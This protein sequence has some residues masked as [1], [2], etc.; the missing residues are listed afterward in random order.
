MLRFGL[1]GTFTYPRNELSKPS[2]ATSS[3]DFSQ[4]S[5]IPKGELHTHL[6]KVLMAMWP[7]M[8]HTRLCHFTTTL[9]TILNVNTVDASDFLVFA[10]SLQL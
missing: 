3:E 7:S 10:Y 5:F 9:L 6:K 1:V 8:Y 2:V 4:I